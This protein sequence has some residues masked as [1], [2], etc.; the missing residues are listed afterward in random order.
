VPATYVSPV[1]LRCTASAHLRST[2]LPAPFT[3]TI[4]VTNNGADFAGTGAVYTYRPAAVP[5]ELLPSSGPLRGGTVVTVRGT[6]FAASTT[7][8]PSSSADAAAGDGSS[9]TAAAIGSSNSTLESVMCHFSFAAGGAVT[10]RAAVV[11]VPA[12]SVSATAVR[13][14]APVSPLL[15]AGSVVLEVA[16]SGGPT[17][18]GLLFY[19]R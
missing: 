3:S 12:L 2:P 14:V 10:P 15:R 11:V 16:D 19:Y 18:A 5:I 4:T 6:G 9:S 7:E 8:A 17:T 1:E 13:C